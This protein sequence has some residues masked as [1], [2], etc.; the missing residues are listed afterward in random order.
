MIPVT[1]SSDGKTVALPASDLVRQP[2]DYGLWVADPVSQHV[3]VTDVLHEQAQGDSVVREVLAA[4]PELRGAAVGRWTGHAFGGPEDLALPYSEVVVPSPAGACPAW[5]FPG[6]ERSS[7]WAIHIHGIWS[8]RTSVLRSVASI[9]DTGVTSLT[10]SYRADGEG[11][12]TL[13]R[14]AMLGS[15]EWIDVEAAIEYAVACGAEEIV[16]VGWSMGAAIALLLSERSKHR[17]LI[18]SLILICPATDTRETLRYWATRSKLPRAAGSL[19]AWAL[20]SRVFSRSIGISEPIDFNELDWTTPGRLKVP[21]LVIHSPGDN[22]V[23]FEQTLSFAKSQSPYVVLEKFPPAA[24][25]ME[26][27]I[28]PTRFRTVVESW[29]LTERGRYTTA[30]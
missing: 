23:P 11:P 16:L 8:S 14:T 25:G 22:D 28:D 5:V 18:T 27:N 26:W 9:A 7:T 24:H 12:S 21:A 1:F 3:R 29:V 17:N 13:N 20:G 15:T 30:R 4:V 2:G 10:A 19:A 6:D